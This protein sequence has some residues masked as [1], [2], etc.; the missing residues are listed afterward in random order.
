MVIK[1][2]GVTIEYNINLE[3]MLLKIP[4]GP[5][6]ERAAIILDHSLGITH[7]PTEGYEIEPLEFDIAALEREEEAMSE[8]FFERLERRRE[9][10]QKKFEQEHG[11]SLDEAVP[12]MVASEAKKK[13]LGDGEAGVQ[14]DN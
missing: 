14:N 1:K 6:R 13:G 11:V 4:A 2:G 7:I 3:E 5:E 10:L 12:A 8:A 9:A